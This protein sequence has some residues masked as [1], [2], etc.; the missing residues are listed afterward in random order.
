MA[1]DRNL[2]DFSAIDLVSE[3]ALIE[4]HWEEGKRLQGCELLT[5][6]EWIEHQAISYQAMLVLG[7]DGML[8]FA[9]RCVVEGVAAAA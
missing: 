3:M 4:E 5:E 2:N 6:D 1:C 7:M 9:R 8:R